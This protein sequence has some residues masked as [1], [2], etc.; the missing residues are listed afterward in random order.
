MRADAAEAEAMAAGGAGVPESV[1]CKDSV[2]CV[3]LFDIDVV[4]SGELF[5]S[6]LAGD[7]F[8]GSCGESRGME[9]ETTGMVDEDGPT[10]VALLLPTKG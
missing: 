4:V 3:V 5:E 9:D 10:S 7:C 6:E 2:V 8:V 1:G